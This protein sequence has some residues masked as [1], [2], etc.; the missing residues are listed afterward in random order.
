MSSVILS[1][2]YL[3]PVQ[4]FAKLYA[5]SSVVEERAEHYVKQTYRNR[6]I[7]AAPSGPQAL[8]IP[9][10]RTGAKTLMRDV[11]ISEHGN[12]RH[13]HWHALITAYEASPFFEYYADDFRPFYER[14]S[15]R[16]LCEFNADLR[17]MVLELLDMRPAIALTEHYAD[18]DALGAIDLRDAI[19]PKHPAEDAHFVAKPYYQV[20]ASRHGFLPNLSIVDLLFNMGPEA[21]LVL[22]DSCV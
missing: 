2:A 20:F 15:H 3:P 17:D 22:R 4:Y 18:A 1:S 13:L 16:Y 21:R 6:C 10:E 12:W 5:A 9:T 7:I 11:R 14:P 19:R 8:T